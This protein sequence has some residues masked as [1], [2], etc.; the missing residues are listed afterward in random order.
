MTD[1][2]HPFDISHLTQA[3]CILLA[4]QLWERARAHPEAIPVTDAQVAELNRRLDAFERGDMP[5]G[6]PWDDVDAW[7][8]TL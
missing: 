5:P 2:S 7:L 6:S 3:E 4:E 1:A 8:A